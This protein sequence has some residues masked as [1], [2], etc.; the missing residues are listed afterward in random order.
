MSKVYRICVFFSFFDFSMVLQQKHTREYGKIFKSHFGPQ[1]V[2]SVADRDLV[3]QVLRAEGAVP[4][5]ANMGSW[6]EYRDLRGRSTGLI[7]A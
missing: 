5:R 1:F 7:S 4:Q 2:V 6:Q 3:A